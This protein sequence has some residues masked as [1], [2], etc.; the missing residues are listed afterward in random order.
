MT[1]YNDAIGAIP[2]VREIDEQVARAQHL[3]SSLRSNYV[4]AQRMDV[5]ADIVAGEV[6]P[7]ELMARAAREIQTDTARQRAQFAANSALSQL[8]A[9][10]PQVVRAGLDDALAVIRA[11]VKRIHDEAQD[12]LPAL[13]SVNAELDVI[14]FG[15]VDEWKRVQQLVSDL[16]A[17]S[18]QW[19]MMR[20]V[21]G[22]LAV[23]EVERC[24][25]VRGRDLIALHRAAGQWS[26][27]GS[28]EESRPTIDL[29]YLRMFA[30]LPF[31]GEFGVWVP[32]V[33]EFA[34]ERR[35]QDERSNARYTLRNRHLVDRDRAHY[36]SVACGN[37]ISR[38][39]NVGGATH[40]SFVMDPEVA[41][42]IGGAE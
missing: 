38:V 21:D 27:T 30:A 2:G 11:E 29:E 25:Y 13:G 41:G 19:E 4:V 1:V 7:D 5:L 22:E 28:F 35:A 33:E 20:E 18:A 39:Q 8:T 17:R 26:P 10:R 3:Y 31:G 24:G 14:N 32:T 36:E 16:H 9:T 42:R 34:E 6:D 12:A 15:L 23:L 40:Y 37:F